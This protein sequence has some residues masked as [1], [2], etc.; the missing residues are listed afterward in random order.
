[1]KSVKS[2]EGTVMQAF[3]V[4]SAINQ[5]PNNMRARA[6]THAHTPRVRLR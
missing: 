3:F 2:W 5:N 4:F 1:M 6:H